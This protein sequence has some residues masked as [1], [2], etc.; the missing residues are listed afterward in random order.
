M[1]E[2]SAV[3]TTH[4]RLDLLKRAIESVLSQTFQEMECIV[5]D[6]ASTDG[7]KEYCE[8]LEGI[9]YIYIPQNESK[10]G[11][12]AR[13]L[14]I[15]AAQG[16]YVAFLDDDD[17]WFPE[18]IQK[19]MSVM[20][21]QD[22]ELVHCGKRDEIVLDDRI[23]FINVIPK[24]NQWGDMSKSILYRFSCTSTTMLIK[25]K[26]LEEIGL[27]DENL[28]YWQDY[29]LLI[30]LAQRKPFGCVEESLILYRIDKK[31]TNRLTHKYFE[32]K[33][34]VRYI[35]KK[36]RNLYSQLDIKES[37]ASIKL[38]LFDAIHRC[39]ASHLYVR[40]FFLEALSVFFR[41]FFR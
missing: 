40:W 1:V 41:I 31:D 14:G 29:E 37:I 19:Q 21:T 9:R 27:F 34:S 18:K 36:H 4:N 16:Q 3:I 35:R 23:D 33:T 25:K 20:L 38:V 24:V 32:W 7:T 6:D 8:K 28:K 26:A 17:A 39:K 2:V 12:H 11:N 22:V 13:N 30:R 10:G 5:V 15:K